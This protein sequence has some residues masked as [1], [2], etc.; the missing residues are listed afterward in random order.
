MGDIKFMGDID[1]DNFCSKF[2]DNLHAISGAAAL[3]SCTMLT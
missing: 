1:K 2:K 3:L